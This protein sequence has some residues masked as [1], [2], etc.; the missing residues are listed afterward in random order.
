MSEDPRAAWT[1]AFVKAQSQLVNPPKRRTAKVK[2]K[3][4]ADYSYS[5]AELPDI[6]DS[7]R[8]VLFEN[9][10]AFAQSVTAPQGSVGV[11]TTI[12]HSGG[13]SQDFGPLYMPA[14][15]TPQEYGSVITY[16]RRYALCAALG[17]AAEDDDDG[18]AASKKSGPAPKPVAPPA[19]SPS[20][21]PDPISPPGEPDGGGELS[22]K[23]K[24]AL[25]AAC[26]PHGRVSDLK[27]DGKTQMP[28]GKLRCEDCGA[29]LDEGSLL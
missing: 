13:H 6:I 1:A 20:V 8:Q 3:T 19:S 11:T 10:L 14:G 4:G 29:V 2:T 15:Q 12:F 26:P 24:G 9:G 22:A 18:A 7:V 5:Y 25:P 27:P 17:I 16:S 23:G 28:K 21:G